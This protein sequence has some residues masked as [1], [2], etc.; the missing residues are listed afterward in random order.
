MFRRIALGTIVVLAMVGVVAAL[1]RVADELPKPLADAARLPER[2]WTRFF[3]PRVPSDARQAGLTGPERE[4]VARLGRRLDALVVWS[5][6]RSGNHELYLLDLGE[7][8]VRQLTHDPHVDFFARFS[9]DGR[10]IVFLRSQREWVSQRD[11]TAWDVYVMNVDGSG[12][13][14]VARGGYYPTW[15]PSGREVVFLR[16]TE[17]LRLDLGTGQESQVIDGATTEGIKGGLETPE[18]SPDGRYLALTA[19]SALYGG[20]AAL[21]LETRELHRLSPG[22]AC[23]LT[24]RPGPGVLWVE[25]GGQG[26]TQIMTAEPPGYER[27]VFMDLP[28]PRSHEYFPRVSRDGRWLV[29]AATAEGHEH[30]RADYELYLW[31]VGTPRESAVRLTHHPGNDQWPDLFVR[32]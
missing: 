28:G 16:G 18:L 15:A 12:E 25:P 27:R 29:W 7:G 8:A 5:S 20:V 19:R 21:D 26:E 13:R 3:A 23:Q 4:A 6:N 9:P 24:W 11:P 22:Q 10:Q 30:D 14:R 31:E 17:V 1:P 32:R 2:L